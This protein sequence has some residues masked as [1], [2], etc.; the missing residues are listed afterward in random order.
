LSH[1]AQQ[2]LEMSLGLH[3]AAHVGE[4]GVELAGVGVGDHAGND[5]VVG[6]RGGTEAVGVGGIEDEAPAAVLEGEAWGR[7]AAAEGE[8]KGRED[9][10]RCQYIYTSVWVCINAPQ[11]LGISPVPNP[12]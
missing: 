5:G 2:Q 3:V 10:I 8:K 1:Q 9:V 12:V 6:A 11:F 4:G 7:V